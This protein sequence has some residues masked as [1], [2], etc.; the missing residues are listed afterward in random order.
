MDEPIIL[1]GCYGVIFGSARVERGIVVV[2]DS[3]QP[4]QRVLLG[5][6]LLCD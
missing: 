4:N 3:L 5:L 1:F 6:K 2:A